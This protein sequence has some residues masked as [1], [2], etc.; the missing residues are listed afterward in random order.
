MMCLN[1]VKYYPYRP[2]EHQVSM[3]Q[4]LEGA[5]EYILLQSQIKTGYWSDAL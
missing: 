2:D 5:G 1:L 3:L 4:R